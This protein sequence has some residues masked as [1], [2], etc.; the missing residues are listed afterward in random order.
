M[1]RIDR[2]TVRAILLFAALVPAACG[3][4]GSQDETGGKSGGPAGAASAAPAAACEL[5][6]QDDASALF[7][8]PASP[9]TG[10][11]GAAMID[12]CLWTWDTESSNQLLQFMIWDPLAYAPPEDST[13]L[14]LGDGGYIRSHP[15]AG[16]DVVWLQGGRMISLTYSTVGPEAPT[17]TSRAE[18]VTALAR[19]VASRL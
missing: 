18:Q 16:V 14:E 17:A 11:R 4:D 10:P 2:S 13:P 3:G 8:Q 9:D 1:M 19:E 15:L 6:S 12:Q 5:V 7:G